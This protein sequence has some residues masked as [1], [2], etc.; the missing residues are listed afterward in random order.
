MSAS[1]IDQRYKSSV[2][3]YSDALAIQR[4]ATT[5]EIINL[6]LEPFEVTMAVKFY[7]LYVNLNRMKCS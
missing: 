4:G 2:P 1:E 3:Y 5:E 7:S 6:N